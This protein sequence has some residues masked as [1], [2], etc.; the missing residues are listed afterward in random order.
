MDILEAIRSVL[1]SYDE[2]KVHL[3]TSILFLI[4]EE[5]NGLSGMASK[6]EEHGI[7]D[8][9]SSW[10]GNDENLPISSDQLTEDIGVNRISSMS[11][12]VGE[13][14]RKQY[15]KT[16]TDDIGKKEALLKEIQHRIKNSFSMITSLINLRADTTLSD[17]TTNVLEELSLRV[18][19]IS[20]LYSLLSETNSFYEIQLKVY[21]HRVI[22]SL[23]NLTKK[24][25]LNKNIANITAP[26]KNAAM[27]GMI[28][29]ELI[30]NSFNYAFPEENAGI[31]NVSL[32]ADDSRI[33]LTVEDNGIGL[34][35][36]FDINNVTSLGLHLVNLMV[37]QL[38]GKID[39]KMEKGT[40]VTIELPIE[41]KR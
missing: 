35:K 10:I 20:D 5:S 25:I 7:G 37:S 22:N 9:F 19:A 16:L 38:D 29:V 23:L 8:V 13:T 30:T 11:D 33:L 41:T 32:E 36:D 14:A 1:I 4:E 28:L 27:I 12:K 15:E 17:E 6:F 34:E 2:N 39:F 40:K 18:K 24:I 26:S 3:I 31:I 21:C